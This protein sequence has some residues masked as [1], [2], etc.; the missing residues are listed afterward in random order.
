MK[1]ENQYLAEG[2]VDLAGTKELLG[3]RAADLED[4]EFTFEV[5]ELDENGVPGQTVVT[6]GESKADGTI[7][8]E[9]IEYK[10]EAGRS[11]IGTHT[12]EIREVAGA[13]E[14][15]DYTDT[16]FT[17]TVEVTDLGERRTGC[18]GSPGG[19]PDSGLPEPVP[20]SRRTDSG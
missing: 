8:F 19:E 2:S 15:V 6:T 5:R 7:D 20:G 13:D 4:G 10:V 12:Y 17:V 9:P 16:V 14:T 1:F 3:N 18:P 11:D